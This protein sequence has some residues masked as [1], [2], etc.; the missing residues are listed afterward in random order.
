MAATALVNEDIAAGHAV[1]EALDARGFP[2][3]AAFW[4]YDSERDVWKLWIGTP[5]AGKD[6]QGAYIKVSEILSASSDR[7][8]FDLARIRLVRPDDPTIRAVG[9]VMRVE[10]ISD[11][12]L[13]SNLANGIYIEDALVYRTAA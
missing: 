7:A 2:V 12:R 1:V 10:G 3:A 9:S 5:R 8:A 11:V 6:L 4:L 13:K